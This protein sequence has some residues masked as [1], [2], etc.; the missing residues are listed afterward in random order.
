VLGD[1]VS[2][3][4]ETHGWSFRAASL[5][6]EVPASTVDRM[7]KGFNVGVEHIIQWAAAVAR[8]EKKDPSAEVRRYLRLANKEHLVGFFTHQQG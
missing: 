6:T 4:L 2:S 1:I 7:S 5:Y 3:V 8:L